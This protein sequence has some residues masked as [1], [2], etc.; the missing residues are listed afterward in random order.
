MNSRTGSPFEQLPAADE[1]TIVQD[2]LSRDRSRSRSLQAVSPPA[3]LPGYE[4]IRSLGEGSFGSVWLAHEVNTGKQVAIKFYTHRRG[5]DWSLLSRE[6]EKLAVLYTSRNV[7]G[8]LGVG[9]DHDPPYFIMEYLENGSLAEALRDGPLPVEDAVRIA[10]SVARALVHA[11]GSGILHCDVKP[12]NVLLDG[13][14]EA[15]L[16]DFGQSRLSNDQSPA[17]GTLFYMAPEQADLEA[18]P[19]ARWDVYAL[20]AL[21]Y[22]MLCGEAPYRTQ[23]PEA[24]ILQAKT[25]AERLSSYQQI[26]K[27]SPPPDGHQRQA[28]VDRLLEEVVD[29]CLQPDPAQRYPNA[30]AVL[31]AL[32]R[33]EQ[34]RGKRPLIALGFIGPLLFLLAMYV[35]ARAAI[36]QAR[37]ASEQNLMDLILEGDA[38]T[39]HILAGSIDQELRFRQE[40]LEA[41]ADTPAARKLIERT[42]TMTDEELYAVCEATLDPAQVEDDPVMALLQLKRAQ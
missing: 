32:D 29:K 13:N 4:I 21:L 28:G 35:I 3:Y 39:A 8:L 5:L 24:R 36:P 19:D 37:E 9:W 33:R 27:Q 20:G 11:H 41:V 15:R 30:Q 17:L 26:I 12:A 6:V 7:V 42:A 38:V 1:G 34:I 14:R 18:I 16:G 25:L 23:S 40:M 22:Q 31:D 2:E 10:R